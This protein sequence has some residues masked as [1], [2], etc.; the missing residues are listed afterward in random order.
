MADKVIAW[1][2]EN[3]YSGVVEKVWWT[4]RWI[5]FNRAVGRTVDSRKN[6]TDVLVRFTGGEFLGVSAKSTK[7]QGD[8]GFKNPGMGQR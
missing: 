6:P 2:K 5:C 4:A 8:I 7:K 3:N 1:S